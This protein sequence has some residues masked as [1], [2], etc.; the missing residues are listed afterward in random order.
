LFAVAVMV[1]GLQAE[2]VTPIDVST[3][4]PGVF[5]MEEL[6]VILRP[7]VQMI[8]TPLIVIV[9]F[10]VLDVTAPGVAMLLDA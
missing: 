4:L 3:A 1:D 7:I 9:V 8:L 10:P 2:I 6:S 5:N